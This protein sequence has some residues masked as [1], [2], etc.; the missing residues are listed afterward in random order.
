MVWVQSCRGF[1]QVMPARQPSPRHPKSCASLNN[2][3]EFCPFIAS[4]SLS[5]EENMLWSP[6]SEIS[7]LFRTSP[8][9]APFDFRAQGLS[10]PVGHQRSS[11]PP[12]SP[13]P[14]LTQPMERA[15]V[16]M[17]LLGL[18]SRRFVAGPPASR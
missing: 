4:T 12:L 5:E 17:R 16:R 3:L 11:C 8:W 10:T 14:E 18:P 15:T 13:N 2:P 1:E 6:W 7:F 9:F